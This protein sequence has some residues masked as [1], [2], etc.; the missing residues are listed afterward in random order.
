MS[1]VK[2]GPSICL[3]HTWF[4]SVT[5][6]G[7]YLM[8]PYLGMSVGHTKPMQIVFDSMSEYVASCW[9]LSCLFEPCQDMLGP[10]QMSQQISES[11]GEDGVSEAHV[12]AFCR[13]LCC[14][15]VCSTCWTM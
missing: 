5:L 6:M 11:S 14:V 15:W 12:K 3:G 8:G 1:L 2:V 4:T 10:Y 13:V 9:G 7:P